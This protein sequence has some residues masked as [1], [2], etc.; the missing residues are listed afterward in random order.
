[1]GSHHP[2]MGSPEWQVPRRCHSSRLMPTSHIG[3][4][5][6]YPL[7]ICGIAGYRGQTLQ[8]WQTVGG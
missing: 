4:T 8:M 6:R 5:G 1:M 2:V 7:N 3:E